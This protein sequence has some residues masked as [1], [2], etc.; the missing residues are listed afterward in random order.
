MARHHEQTRVDHTCHTARLCRLASSASS[1]LRRLLLPRA[2]LLWEL[3][4]RP[5][6]LTHPLPYSPSAC[7]PSLSSSSSSIGINERDF[8][9]LTEGPA[10]LVEE[11][12]DVT[13]NGFGAGGCKGETGRREEPSTDDRPSVSSLC[14]VV[15]EEV[16]FF[17]AVAVT[18]A[19]GTGSGFRIFV[20][21]LGSA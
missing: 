11:E 21:S 10:A 14:I 20:F 18:G 15:V 6:V 17:G 7:V 5:S 19:G 1:T 13:V 4:R 12:L 16:R 3:R 8:L 2:A 9:R